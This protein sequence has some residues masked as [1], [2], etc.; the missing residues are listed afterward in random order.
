MRR[1]RL[2]I[3]LS[4][5]WTCA[6]PAQPRLPDGPGK[7]IIEQSCLGCHEPNRIL[8]SGYSRT[9]WQNVLH[10][11]QNVGAP[12]P[13]DQVAPLTD[14]LA[15]NFPEKPKPAPSLLAGSTQVEFKEWVVPTPGTRPHDPL[16]YPD[17]SI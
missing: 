1:C 17:G 11:M 5:S 4:L 15:Q 14:Y 3:L 9:D 7:A 10:M 12:L 13:A 8:N 2:A 16:A 6:A